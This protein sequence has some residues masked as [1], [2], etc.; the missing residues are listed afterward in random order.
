MKSSEHQ[1]AMVK[2]RKN[3]SHH[4]GITDEAA[5]AGITTVGVQFFM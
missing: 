4:P 3:V 2:D 5:D 1:E